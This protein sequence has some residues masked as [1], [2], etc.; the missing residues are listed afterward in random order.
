MANRGEELPATIIF[1]ER[2]LVLTT[3]NTEA[4]SD[5]H[6]QE[7]SFQRGRRTLVVAV[8][9][10]HALGQTVV[11]E[12]GIEHIGIDTFFLGAAKGASETTNVESRCIDID[13]PLLELL[14]QIGL[15][16]KEVNPF[17]HAPAIDQIEDN[18][19]IGEKEI[20]MH[21][22]KRGYMAYCRWWCVRFSSTRSLATVAGWE[23]YARRELKSGGVFAS[24]IIENIRT[25][26]S[27]ANVP[28]KL[29]L[30]LA[31]KTKAIGLGG[32][33]AERFFASLHCCIF[34]YAPEVLCAPWCL[35]ACTLLRAP[36][37][38]R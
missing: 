8:E 12:V 22:L 14:G 2:V 20:K 32:T 34:L 25:C 5:V 11:M 17:I 9:Y 1:C 6:V 15:M 38:L 24:K 30:L 26:P 29:R 16:V 10:L 4:L 35:C 27:E 28:K 31:L 13:Q 36:W 18:V 3:C 21:L 23:R 19:I 33:V 37:D 7:E